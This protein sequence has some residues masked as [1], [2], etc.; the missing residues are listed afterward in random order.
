[1]DKK[2]IIVEE[3]EEYVYLSWDK[4][5]D[6]T[7]YKI[8]GMNKLFIYEQI[9]KTT[10]NTAKIEK[11]KLKNYIGIRVDYVLKNKELPKEIL[12]G[13]TNSVYLN[14]KD[15]KDISLSALR[16]YRGI[17][18][19]FN[20][21]GVYDKYYLYEKVN[22]K[23]E[24]LMILE[25]FQVNNDLIK[26]GKTYY[27]EAYKK[28][29]DKYVL[30]AK[31]NDYVCTVTKRETLTGKPKISVVI[32]VY[33]SEGF[34]ERCIDSVL[35]S[36]QKDIEIVVVDD[37]STDSS[38]IIV[39]WYSNYYKGIVRVHHKKNGG[40]SFAR[41]KG[42]ELATGDYIGL[43]DNDDLVHPRMYEALYTSLIANDSP[44]AIGKTLIREGVE[45]SS[46]CLDIK[47][48][49]DKDYISYT[50]DEMIH[51]KNTFDAKNIYF[52]AVWNKIIRSDLMKEHPLPPYNH[53]EDTAYTRMIYSYI[54]KF[55][56]SPDAYYIWD[57]RRRK[58]TGTASTYYYT[59]ETKDEYLYHRIYRDSSFYA[60]VAG[61]P[62]KMD[63]IL[64][65][66]FKETYE[67]LKDNK[68]LDK[69][70]VLYEI[71]GEPIIEL[72]K[73]YN[74]LNIKLIKEHKELYKY[75]KELLNR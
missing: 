8:V 69:D 62:D 31:S 26:E 6:A 46:I 44:I 12:L 18:L 72:D 43:L 10:K 3:T 35:F 56:F 63:Y 68:G 45:D 5:E 4:S 15:Y 59:N 20:M 65:D 60:T 42:I 38:P 1:M 24:L 13:K 53:Y 30:K 64:Y 75:L 22:N 11:K 21:E 23:Y 28:E 32:P 39:D 73:K 67:Y 47:K 9:L 25:D 49:E 19:S 14:K 34:I 40:V 52:V 17:T 61:N 29:E 74:V 55:T 36:T 2:L 7:H 54:D 51:Y 58:T 50:Y 37:E 57:K 16:S 70:N 33:N 48:P 41:N 71:Y 66:T 27:V